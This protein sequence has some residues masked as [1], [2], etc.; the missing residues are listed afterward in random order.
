MEI[1]EEVGLITCERQIIDQ[2]PDSSIGGVPVGSCLDEVHMEEKRVKVQVQAEEEEKEKH[3]EENMVRKKERTNNHSSAW[4][5]DGMTR[6]DTRA[7]VVSHI[8]QYAHCVGEKMTCEVCC[9]HFPCRCGKLFRLDPAI[10][11]AHV[12]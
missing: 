8:I 12:R 10:L 11:E 3:T 5:M 9:L 7:N 6:T 2:R 4:H 1:V